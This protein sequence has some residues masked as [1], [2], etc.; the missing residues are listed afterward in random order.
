MRK[1]NKIHGIFNCSASASISSSV[2]SWTKQSKSKKDGTSC[3]SDNRNVLLWWNNREAMRH[4]VRKGKVRQICAPQVRDGASMNP[5]RKAGPERHSVLKS[6]FLLES[7]QRDSRRRGCCRK[8]SG[9]PVKGQKQSRSWVSERPSGAKKESRTLTT[10]LNPLP[11]DLWPSNVR[12]LDLPPDKQEEV[13][14]TIWNGLT[15]SF[16]LGR[17]WHSRTGYWSHMVK[18]DQGREGRAAEL[19]KENWSQPRNLQLTDLCLI[20]E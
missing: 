3:I 6:S 17:Q 19:M 13:P 8:I 18:W 12:R 1:E 9:E 2:S 15:L 20:K 7:G 14:E 16:S 10:I 4:E 11:A 5:V